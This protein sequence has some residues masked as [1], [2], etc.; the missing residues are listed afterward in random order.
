MAAPLD[1]AH[2]LNTPEDQEKRAAL[3][4]NLGRADRTHRGFNNYATGLLLCPIDYDW[5]LP[6]YFDLF[7]CRGT[8]HFGL[9]LK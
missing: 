1:N 5:S 8:L 4:V 9:A 2:P 6:R 7:L 3:L